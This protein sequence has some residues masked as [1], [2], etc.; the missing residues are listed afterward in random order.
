MTV[1]VRFPAGPAVPVDGLLADLAREPDGGWLGFGDQRIRD[2][3]AALARRLLRPDLAREYPE[4]GSLGFFLRQGELLRALRRLD[5]ETREVRRVPRGLVLHFPPANVDTIFVYSWALSALAGN[6]NIVRVSGRSAGAAASILGALNDVL[7][8][9]HPAVAQTQRMI[10]YQR[11]EETTEALSA[12]CDLRVIWGGDRSV[13]ELRRFP[14]RP[15]AR[16]LTFPDRSSFA[17]VSVPGWQRATPQARRAAVG[18]FANDVF[19]FDQAACSSPRT[20]FWVGDQDAAG[21]ARAEFMALLGEVVDRRGWRVD[22]AMAVQKRVATYGLAATGAATRL[23]FAGNAVA[24]VDL[25]GDT[26]ARDWL[27]AGTICH[28]SVGSLADLVERIGRKDQTFSEF[29]FTCAELDAFVTSL[30]GR[31]I[32]RIVPFGS[33]LA[34]AGTWDGYDLLREFTRLTT[35]R[36]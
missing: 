34:F 25:A 19:W 23:S 32:D 6:R 16:D 27:G 4:L 14:L 17:A 36:T 13:T 3:L 10:T 20:L 28:L 30:A 35:I 18:G 21:P 24:S 5:G 22:A 11:D 12:G 31:G 29:G 33:A 7:Q 15:L 2:F 26:P 1:E 8:R 9:A